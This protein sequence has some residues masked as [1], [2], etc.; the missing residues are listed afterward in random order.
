MAKDKDN[1]ED[2]IE[3]PGFG[4]IADLEAGIV[5]EPRY[6]D[7]DTSGLRAIDDPKVREDLGLDAPSDDPNDL[8]N[9]MAG[10]QAAMDKIVAGLKEAEQLKDEP[11]PLGDDDLGKSR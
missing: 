11:I 8:S 6:S 9:V 1:N 7:V 4:D 2:R 10:G 3:L 5:P